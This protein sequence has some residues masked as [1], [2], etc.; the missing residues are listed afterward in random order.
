MNKTGITVEE[1]VSVI[2]SHQN[3]RRALT[4][5]GYDLLIVD[6]PAICTTETA[7]GGQWAPRAI[8]DYV[9]RQFVQLAGEEKFH[10]VL[11]AQSNREGAKV[12][13]NYDGD[14]NRLLTPED[15]S[16]AYGPTMSATNIFTL[17][18]D[19]RA[20]QANRMTWYLCKSRSGSVG[21]AV[22]CRTDFT[23]ALTHSPELACTAWNGN[24]AM[25]D[26]IEKYLQQYNQLDIPVGYT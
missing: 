2:H 6:Y 18:R 4:G 10:A 14:D 1:V 3:R 15:I 19:P 24:H 13:R 9:Y 20:Q 12:N 22:C 25:P 23:K 11:A 16:E 21:W 8:L 17:N 5:K 7:K 26:K